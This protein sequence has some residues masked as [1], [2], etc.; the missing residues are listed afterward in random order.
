MQIAHGRKILG[1]PFKE[2]VLDKGLSSFPQYQGVF[3]LSH[4]DNTLARKPW[5]NKPSHPADQVKA[6]SITPTFI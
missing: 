2:H 3:L 6:Y 5:L 4:Y 1:I